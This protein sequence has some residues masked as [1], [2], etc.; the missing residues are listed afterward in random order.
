MLVYCDSV[1]LI[2]YLDHTGTFQ[3]RA[4]THLAA[5]AQAGAAL[6]V[7]DLVRMEYRVGPLRRNDPAAL[8]E[9]DR[10]V[11]QQNVQTAPL[12]T[13]VFDRAALLRATHRFTTT[14]AVHL[15]AAIVHGCDRVLTNDTRLSA[16]PDIPI[17]ILP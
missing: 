10:F 6:A 9:F 3:V 1:I 4:A 16:C 2:Y 13:A 12:T 17:D 5:L 11:G 7:S 8:A 15:A 14:D